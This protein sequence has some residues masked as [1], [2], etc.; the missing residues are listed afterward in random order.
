MKRKLSFIVLIVEIFAISLLHALKMN[1]PASDSQEF[2]AQ[3][4][5]IP[6]KF[7]TKQ[8]MSITLIS[9]PFSK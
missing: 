9:N 8:D 3:A 1:H 5:S 7:A 4:N 2:R 6:A